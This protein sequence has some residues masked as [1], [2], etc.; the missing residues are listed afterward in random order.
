LLDTGS[1]SRIGVAALTVVAIAAVAGIVL[2]LSRSGQGNPSAHFP[3]PSPPRF[4]GSISL[5]TVLTGND[6]LDFPVAGGSRLTSLPLGGNQW[7]VVAAADLTNFSNQLLVIDEP[8]AVAGRGESG[9]VIVESA[10]IT[11]TRNASATEPPPLLTRIQAAQNVD[12]WIR[13]R[14]DCNALRAQDRS[15]S[16]MGV[17]IPL[18]GLPPAVFEFGDLF[19]ID[20]GSAQP[21]CGS[22]TR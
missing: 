17:I 11:A 2:A 15:L 12:V 3:P 1:R 8:I 19:G 18:S 9:A 13:L 20:P 5:P 6:V 22:Q 16:G 21:P 7:V 14:V 10:E 4:T